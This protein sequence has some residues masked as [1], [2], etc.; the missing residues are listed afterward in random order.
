MNNLRFGKIVI[1]IS[2]VENFILEIPLLAFSWICRFPRNCIPGCFQSSL[3]S[4]GRLSGVTV[5]LSLAR[6]YGHWLLQSC[7]ILAPIRRLF[8]A[9][10]LA[11]RHMSFGSASASPDCSCAS[12]LLLSYGQASCVWDHRPWPSPLAPEPAAHFGSWAQQGAC[13]AHGFAS[14]SLFARC[15]SLAVGWRH[16]CE[17]TRGPGLFG[18]VDFFGRSKVG[19]LSRLVH[20]WSTCEKRRFVVLISSQF[21]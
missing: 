18:T 5:Q 3:C 14:R 7:S 4:M 17:W 19:F 11:F 10:F 20:N 9:R 13:L 12:P 16:R 6:C 21:L 15:L 1:F 8:L 2:F